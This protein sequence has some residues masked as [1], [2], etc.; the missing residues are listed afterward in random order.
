LTKEEG[1]VIS[2]APRNE[3]PKIIRIVKNNKLKVA[4]L[5]AS[6]KAEAPKINVM[7]KPRAT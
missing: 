4:L 7:S 5:A 2:K 1:S 3:I 6:F